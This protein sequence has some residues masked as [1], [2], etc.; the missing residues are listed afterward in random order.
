MGS[1]EARLAIA[2][3]L[4]LMLPATEERRE[5]TKPDAILEE[6]FQWY[7]Q[8]SAVR[9]A[10]SVFARCSVHIVPTKTGDDV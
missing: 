3:N 2:Y 4:L 10:A 6:T 1:R 7:F 5:L 8:R 9:F